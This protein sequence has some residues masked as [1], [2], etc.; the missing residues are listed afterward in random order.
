MANGTEN[1]NVS[2]LAATLTQLAPRIG[3]IF[4]GLQFVVDQPLVRQP[5]ILPTSQAG[6]QVIAAGATN[7]PLLQSD[8]SHSLEWP[9]EIY[10]IRFSNDPQH[11]FRDWRIM[12]LD[13]TF[14]QQWMKN[15]VMVDDLID[16]NT[17]FWELPFP[18]VI[19]PQG[20]GQNFNIDNLD[21]VNPIAVNIALH[22]CLLIPR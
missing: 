16:A 6:G 7:V 8:F 13:L 9:F 22:G 3:R 2:A 4:K 14:N 12:L 10:R 15:P 18:W 17:G 19:R 1:P 21:T 5:Y 11:T 20:G